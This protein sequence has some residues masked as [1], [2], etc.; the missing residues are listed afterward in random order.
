MCLDESTDITD[1]NQLS[2]FVRIID[3][4]F[5]I[6]EELLALV[7]M[8]GT[9]KGVNIFNA[10]RQEVQKYGGFAKCTAIVTDEATAMVGHVNGFRGLLKTHGITCHT[11]HCIIHQK[12]LCGKILMLSSTMKIV[13][14]ITNLIRGGNRALSYRKFQNF[15]K[16]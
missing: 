1:I 15:W 13:T 11:Y 6:H 3:N 7:P 8:H 2:I 5:C 12:A 16:K 4:E 9:T 14:K 10:V